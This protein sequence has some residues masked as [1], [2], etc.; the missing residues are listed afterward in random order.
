MKFIIGILCLSSLLSQRVWAQSTPADKQNAFLYPEL[1]VSPRASERISMESKT[2]ARTRRTQLLPI[3]ISA[4]STLL[5]AAGAPNP[6]DEHKK[7]RDD[8]KYSRQVA[9]GVSVSWLVF[10][11]FFN[12]DYIPYTRAAVM[13]KT[14]PDKSPQEELVR[15]RIAEE[16]IEAA[17]SLGKK[18]MWASVVTNL[19]AAAYLG[20]NTEKEGEVYAAAAAILAFTPVVFKDRWQTVNRYHQEYK[21]RIYGPITLP[22]LMS[23]LSLQASN[24]GPVPGVFWHLSF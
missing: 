9:M 12:E 19:A 20:S 23:P 8:V 6:T 22:T 7:D 1:Q 10:S 13:L 5:A 4:L 17:S 14:L 16:Q 3:Q 21:K 15:E 18:M 11:Y 24:S 2:E